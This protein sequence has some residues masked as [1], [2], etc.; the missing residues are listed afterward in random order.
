MKTPTLSAILMALV[1]LIG[2]CSDGDDSLKTTGRLNVFLVDEPFPTNMVAEAN[3]TIFKVDARLTE[4]ED[5]G[6]QEF[7]EDGDS[8]GGFITLMDESTGQINLLDLRDD[9]KEQLVSMEVPAGT[10]DLIRVYVQD[11]NIIMKGESQAEYDLKVPSGAQSGIK[12]FLDPPLQVVGGLSTDLILDFDVNK[13][14]IPKGGSPNNPEGITGFNFTPVIRA[15]I[16]S[17]TG[18]ITGIVTDEN[19]TPLEDVNVT[20]FAVGDSYEASS[21]TVDTGSYTI[22]GLNPG[23][24]EIEVSLEGYKSQEVDGIE[25][26]ANNKTTVEDIVLVPVAETT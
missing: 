8:Q 20:A 13:S 11:P 21:S 10:Y 9:V 6:D 5:E 16:T 19:G 4:V 24:Y 1:L 17:T 22:S 25:V 23:I 18:S 14:F 3:V 26:I 15:S 7:L 2:G 12:V